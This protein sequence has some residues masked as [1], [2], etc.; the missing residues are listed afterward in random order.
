MNEEFPRDTWHIQGDGAMA[1]GSHLW[2]AQAMAHRNFGDS[3]TM[4][5]DTLEAVYVQYI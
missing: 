5:F 4:G 1:Q 2:Q 3:Q